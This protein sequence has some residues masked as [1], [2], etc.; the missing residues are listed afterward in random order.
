MFHCDNN[1]VVSIWSKGSTSSGELMTLVRTLYF[2]A[3]RYNMHIMITH[4]IGT[5]NCIADAISHFQMDRFRSPAPHA[6]PHAD[7]ILQPSVLD[8]LSRAWMIPP[9]ITYVLHLVCRGIRRLQGDKIRK[10]LPITINLL[11]TLKSQL[12]NSTFLTV[13]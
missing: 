11:K 5:K 8:T 10:R 12:A 1:T 7:P 13:L 2:C 4:I 9:T 3:A 6:N